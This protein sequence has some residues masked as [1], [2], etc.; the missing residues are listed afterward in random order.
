MFANALIVTC[1]RTGSTLLM[2]LLNA[3]PGVVIR[4]ENH[5][6][7]FGLHQ[8]HQSLLAWA[9][10]A[11]KDGSVAD[12]F[13][14]GRDL[15]PERFITQARELLRTQLLGEA[16]ARCWGF[17]EIRYTRM[18]EAGKALGPYLDFLDLLLERPL[19][20][21]LTR[22]HEEVLGSGF[23][24]QVGGGAG[25]PPVSLVRHFEDDMR[26]WAQGRDNVTWIDY[27]NVVAQD[28]VLH[29]LCTR[30][31]GDAWAPE[32]LRQAAQLEYSYDNRR[33]RLREQVRQWRHLDVTRQ[34]PDPGPEVVWFEVRACPR[35]V[36]PS[37]PFTFIG[38]AILRRGRL[39][40]R[41][42]PGVVT[43]LTPG[44]R[45]PQYGQQ[46]QQAHNSGHSKFEWHI[47]PDTPGQFCEL[48][49]EDEA[50]GAQRLLVRLDFA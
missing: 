37:Q 42:A 28:D 10:S 3:L 39:C 2:G 18:N 31:V 23:W 32:A 22:Q 9:A 47:T 14:G 27:R 6:F 20:I 4:G 29:A 36:R 16:P 45:S 15:Q 25:Q 49:W 17:K 50:T 19:F 11:S 26:A 8:A 13:H 5:S 21:V 33:E 34:V 24:P 43:Q 44:M 12:P 46:H 40:E 35:R 7:C 1:G 38:I 30:L 41:L 48:Y